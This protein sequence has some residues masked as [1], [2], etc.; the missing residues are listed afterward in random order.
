MSLESAKSFVTKV[1]SDEE[2][3][4]ELRNCKDEMELHAFAEQNGYIFTTEELEGAVKEIAEAELE[5]ES[6]QNDQVGG[7]GLS[8]VGIDYIFVTVSAC[9][10]LCS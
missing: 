4:K 10:N 3:A 5:I 7:V 9:A 1:K 2:F 6:E 8:L